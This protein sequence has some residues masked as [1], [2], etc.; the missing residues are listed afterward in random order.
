MIMYDCEVLSSGL[1]K[2]TISNIKTAAKCMD[3]RMRWSGGHGRT[4][5]FNFN[6]SWAR[7][8]PESLE[9]FKLHL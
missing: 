3:E 7:L 8:M 4:R 9:E 5:G 6:E 2:H 1:F